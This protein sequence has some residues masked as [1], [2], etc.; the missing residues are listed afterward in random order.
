MGTVSGNTTEFATATGSTPS[1]DCA[2]WDA[3]GNIVDAGSPCGGT[4]PTLSTYSASRYYT[5]LGMASGAGIASTANVIACSKGMVLNELTLSVLTF[6]ITTIGS[7]NVQAALYRDI[8]GLPGTLLASAPSA[9]DTSTLGVNL[10]LGSSVQI[11]P[12][13]T[14]GKNSVWVCTNV[15]DST[16]VFTANSRAAGPQTALMG[17]PV[18]AAGLVGT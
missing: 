11:G 2:K 7:S 9:V 17:A 12:G 5:F 13:S 16:V 6:N 3:S 15:N 18:T 1:G 4:G 14:Y 10:T 8:G